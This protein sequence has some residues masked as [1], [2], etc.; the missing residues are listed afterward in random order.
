MVALKAFHKRIVNGMQKVRKNVRLTNYLKFLSR[1]LKGIILK[2]SANKIVMQAA[3][4]YLCYSEKCN[5]ENTVF[6][7]KPVFI[8]KE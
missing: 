2:N 6:K 4:N 7:R 5:R 3:L 1:W 8:E